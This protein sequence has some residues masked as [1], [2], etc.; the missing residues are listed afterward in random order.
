MMPPGGVTTGRGA[1][2]RGDPGADPVG[3]GERCACTRGRGMVMAVPKGEF[4]GMFGPPAQIR[5]DGSFSIGGLSPNTYT[6]QVMGPSGPDN[7]YASAEVT[8]SGDDVTAVQLVAT[9]PILVSGR[10]IVDP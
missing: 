10:V 2:E 8:I 1:G 4:M 5:P 3:S 6:V 7:E 9:K